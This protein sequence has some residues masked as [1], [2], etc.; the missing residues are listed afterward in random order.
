LRSSDAVAAFPDGLDHRGVAEL[1]PQPLDGG[2]HGPGERVGRF[3]PYPFEQFLGRDRPSVRG[4]QAFQHGEF[5]AGQRQAPPG[6]DRDPASRVHAQVAVGEGDGQRSGG[7][8]AQGPDAG[9]QFG[10]IERLRQVIIGAQPEALDPVPNRPGRGQHQH[11]AL[12]SARGKDP[13]DVIAVRAGQVPVQHHH[14]IAVDRCVIEGCVA[15]QGHV[16]GHAL[17]AQP[18]GHRPGQELVILGYQHSHRMSRCFLRSVYV[19][20]PRFTGSQVAGNSQA[21]FSVA[22]TLRPILYNCLRRG[23]AEARPRL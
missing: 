9:H 5:L 4:E 8:P 12:G 23:G 18:G 22:A 7:A 19:S 17:A 14:V 3:I 6:A 16:D 11:P 20:Q 21:T 10:E 13:A 1:G 2:L 15:V